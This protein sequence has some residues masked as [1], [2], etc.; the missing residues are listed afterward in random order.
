M[1][2]L[3]TV[4]GPC[5]DPVEVPVTSAGSSGAVT[6]DEW[7]QA[8]ERDGY[9]VVRGAIPVER[10]AAVRE[11]FERDVRPHRGFLFRQTTGRPERNRFDE[12]GHLA[13][14][15][16]DVQDVP[17]ALEAFRRACL[18]LLGDDVLIAI[19]ESLAGESVRLV[20]TMLFEA[21]AATR[22]HQDSYFL[23][24][25][26]VGALNAAWIALEEIGPGAGRFWVSPGSHRRDL[27]LPHGDTESA[28]H[29]DR[30]LETVEQRVR[31][32]FLPVA[33]PALVPGD[34]LVWNSRTVHGSLPTS[35][36]GTSRL[37]LTAHYIPASAGFLQLRS[38]EVPL[39]LEDV[40]GLSVHHRRDQRRLPGRVTAELAGRF[41]GPYV[42]AKRCA[43]W[44]LGR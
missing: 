12:H 11:T 1:S 40:S 30:Y 18:E 4:R 15:I 20:Q 32:D 5:G 3:R 27:A 9:V 34:V 21:N 19:M 8:M 23:D 39:Q 36:E 13:N 33:A 31:E 25:T 29:L 35:D 43:K 10:C 37:S 16:H 14:P 2:D 22:A 7:R 44:A 17:P 41:P 42:F 24:S 6:Q 28:F 26:R 38:R